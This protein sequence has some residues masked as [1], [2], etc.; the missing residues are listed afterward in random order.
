VTVAPTAAAAQEPTDRPLAHADGLE[1]VGEFQ[2]SGFVEPPSIVRL[3]SGQ[4]IQLTE[5]LY[6]VLSCI[7][8][9][10]DLVAI[11]AAVSESIGKTATADDVRYLVEEKLR[12]LGVLKNAD[13]TDPP[14]QPSDPLLGI[15]GR[16]TLANERV[17]NGLG[18]LFQPLFLPPVVLAVL[19]AFV[20]FTGWLFFGEGLGQGA[21]QL[22]YSPGMLVLTFVL[23]AVSA[24]FHEFGH[25][26]ACKYGGARPGVI[27]GGIY[28]VWPVFY[29][30]VTDSYRLSRGGRLRTDFGGIYFN[31]LFSLA[32]LGVWT[33]TRYDALLVLVPLQ[34]L[35]MTQQLMPFVR[36]DGYY[37]LADLT[38]VPDLF[39]RIKPTVLAAVPGHDAGSRVTA[40]KPWVR[41]V[42][43]LWVIAVV[44]IILMSVST[45]IIGLPRL[46]A[47]VGDSVGRQWLGLRLAAERG[48]VMRVIAGGIATI[49]VALPAASVVYMFGR[50]VRRVARTL[51]RRT[52][53]RPVARAGLA[54]LA[55]AAT[56]GLAWLWW[57]NGEYEPLHKGERWTVQETAANVRHIPGGRPGYTPTRQ[58][59]LT[60]QTTTTVAP[61]TTTTTLGDRDERTTETTRTRAGT[62]TTREPATTP[63]TAEADPTETT[64]P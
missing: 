17:T 42:V 9:Q 48:A 43:T 61:S 45:A 14:L 39:A 38:G 29:T 37:I 5:L 59:E 47:T 23:T 34:I 2:H 15:K 26:A 41:V 20:G 22:L 1:L 25:A 19:A 53:G 31:T 50:I 10:R 64:T 16:F 24:G 35:Q 62:P 11:A 33:V 13:G 58:Q 6:V 12:P 54:P 32:T 55:L 21:R 4:T 27:G 60:S 30:D 51:W 18:A 52:D 40:L 28:L 7:D 56:A 44:P 63:T 49:A 8:G 57:P 3:A 46:L 36:F